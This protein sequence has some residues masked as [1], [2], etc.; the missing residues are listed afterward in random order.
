MDDELQK[1]EQARSV[2]RLELSASEGLNQGQ[3]KEVEFTG[4]V[5]DPSQRFA[6]RKWLKN[7]CSTALTAVII[8]T[9]QALRNI[10]LM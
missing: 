6:K 9:E 1:D 2:M 7:A 8:L 10:D 4:F 3:D 5:T